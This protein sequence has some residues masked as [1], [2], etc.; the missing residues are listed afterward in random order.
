MMVKGG[1]GV[2]LDAW[3]FV[4][5]AHAP[6]QILGRGV[7]GEARAIGILE[8]DGLGGQSTARRPLLFELV[9][10]ASRVHEEIRDQGRDFDIVVVDLLRDNLEGVAAPWSGAVLGAN[11]LRE[12]H[13][14]RMLGAAWFQ[15]GAEF[16]K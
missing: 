6:A 7:V 12:Q 13:R 15:L 8:I 5:V 9:H 11:R 1:Q 4:A 3:S 14:M 16:K 10:G 2:Y